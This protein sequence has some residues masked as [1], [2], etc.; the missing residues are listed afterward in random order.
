[1][2]R[3]GNGITLCRPCHTT[4]MFDQHYVAVNPETSLLEVANAL[5]DSKQERIRLKWYP[6]VQKLITARTKRGRWPTKEAFK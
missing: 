1:V 2:F 3:S 5:I 4:G 6:L